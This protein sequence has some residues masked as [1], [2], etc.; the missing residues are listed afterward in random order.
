MSTSGDDH[1]PHQFKFE[2]LNPHSHVQNNPIPIFSSLHLHPHLSPLTLNQKYEVSNFMPQTS[3]TEASPTLSRTVN[4]PPLQT[5]P[6]IGGKHQ[7]KSKVSRKSGINKSNIESPNLAAV[8]NCRY[9]S[10]LGLLTKKFVSLIH[11]AK[12]ATLDLNKSTEILQVQKRRIYDITNVL[13]GI[14]LI[15]KTSKNHIRWKAYDGYGQH[16]LDDQVTRLKAEVESLYAEEFNLDECIRKNQELLRNL[17]ERK[18]SQ[19]YL[20]VT[21]EDILNL[22]CFQDQELIAI[23]APQASF[24]EV[25]DPDEEFGFRQKQYKMTVRSAT[26]PISLHLL[27]KRKS[28]FED[29]SIKQVQL[30]DQPWNSD[31]CRMRSVGLLE[32]QDDQQNAPQS[33]QSLSS[34]EFEIQEITPRDCEVEDDYWFQTD[35]GV[36]LTDLWGGSNF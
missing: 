2:L 7:N 35:P 21:K 36:S 24:I 10:S 19:K 15:E 8:S 1:R 17:Q 9:D 22:P 26:G 3:T 12:D 31:H 27:S 16:D 33:Y 20:F 32:G 14:G 6:V 28:N 25:P 5:E 13:E 29:S 23:K 11:E 34:E 4:L 30:I 18:N